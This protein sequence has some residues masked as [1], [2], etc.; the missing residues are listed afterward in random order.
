MTDRFAFAR[1]ANINNV[2]SYD[3]YTLDEVLYNTSKCKLSDDVYKIFNRTY[4]IRNTLDPVSK[5]QFMKLVSKDQHD[6]TK[7]KKHMTRLLNSISNKGNNNIILAKIEII[8]TIGFQYMK[9][10]L[11]L[12]VDSVCRLQLN[13]LQNET[14]RNLLNTY[15]D[16]Y[17]HYQ[18]E[19]PIADCTTYLM[20]KFNTLNPLSKM[21]YINF[22][23][24]MLG[25]H[26]SGYIKSSVLDTM[27]NSLLS[28]I[29][30]SDSSKEHREVAIETYRALLLNIESTE[31]MKYIGSIDNINKMRELDISP[32]IKVL[33]FDIID[34]IKKEE[35]KE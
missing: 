33:L 3:E 17:V 4:K 19:R 13:T 16:L 32:R 34:I 2:I 9:F 27:I 20:N 7:L 26:K 1:K 35:K 18:L 25:I 29:S 6:A 28:T 22:H 8:A 12:I 15:L 31:A 23:M 21:P 14:S 5:A 30:S 11:N 10:L 24:F